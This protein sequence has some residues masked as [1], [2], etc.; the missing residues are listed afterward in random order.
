V[1]VG[2]IYYLVVSTLISP[3]GGECV[4]FSLMGTVTVPLI[5]ELSGN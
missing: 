4:D 1:V 3:N 5:S 2:G